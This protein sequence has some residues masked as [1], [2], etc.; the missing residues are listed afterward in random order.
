[1]QTLEFDVACTENAKSL[2]GLGYRGKIVTWRSDPEAR[3]DFGPYKPFA[4][5][6]VNARTD[7]LCQLHELGVRR[8][9]LPLFDGNYRRAGNAQLLGQL[10]L[11]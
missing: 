10:R 9:P 7:N 4:Q 1:M 6:V 2:D 5:E 11:R 8:S 3:R